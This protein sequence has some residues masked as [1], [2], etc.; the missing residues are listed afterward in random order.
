L[1]RQKGA[2]TATFQYFRR[3]S[4]KEANGNHQQKRER[5]TTLAQ[6]QTTA[7]LSGMH[8]RP[9]ARRGTQEGRDFKKSR[10]TGAAPSA[11]KE[12]KKKRGKGEGDSPE[13]FPER[14]KNRKFTAQTTEARILFSTSH[15]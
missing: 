5:V 10:K 4:G 14:V 9:R 7:E 15:G 8:N 13:I 3:L 11:N 12:K 2:D 1:T 6:P